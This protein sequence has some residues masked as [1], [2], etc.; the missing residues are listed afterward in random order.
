MESTPVEL[1]AATVRWLAGLPVARTAA[2][3]LV[4]LLP[5]A[6][7]GPRTGPTKAGAPT[8]AR[9]YLLP[10]EAVED[11]LGGGALLCHLV[12]ALENT[13][14]CTIFLRKNPKVAVEKALSVLRES[15]HRHASVW[16]PACQRVHPA[17]DMRNACIG[18]A[19]F[20]R[21]RCGRCRAHHACVS[22]LRCGSTG[23][24]PRIPFR[25]LWSGAA[26]LENDV[27]IGLEL[28]DDIRRAY[29]L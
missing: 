27:R 26:V 22:F 5:T 21:C 2:R 20:D 19:Q 16:P 6:A 23:A 12:N 17:F 14:S 13:S 9:P 1:S 25:H 28:L 11:V 15:H 18:A 10:L 4:A 3:S 24:K 29:T 7:R 8:T